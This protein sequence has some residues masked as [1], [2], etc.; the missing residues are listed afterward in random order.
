MSRFIPHPEALR[1]GEALAAL[2]RERGLSQAEAG[3]RLDMTSQGWGL[4]EAGRR[5]GLFRPD[6]QRRLT[7]ALDSTPEALALALSTTTAPSPP[8]TPVASAAKAVESR[9]RD[10]AGAEP[11]LRRLQILNDD[12]SPWADSGVVVEYALGVWPRRGQGCV[13]EMGGETRVRIYETG[14]A[15]TV[16]VRGASSADAPE[17][18]AR[19]TIDRLSAVVA[20]IERQ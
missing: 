20:R 17:V 15:R 2:R 3:A 16:T 9:R 18:L 10:F 11:Q 6:V 7:G 1:L 12:L 4:Y 19:Q 8:A 13:I 14:D 5:S